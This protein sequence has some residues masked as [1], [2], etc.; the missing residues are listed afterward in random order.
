MFE[1]VVRGSEQS[2]RQAF[3]SLIDIDV[4]LVFGIAL[5]LAYGVSR[6]VVAELL[7]FLKWLTTYGERIDDSEQVLRIRRIETYFS[8][9]LALVRAFIFV[10]AIFAAWQYTHPEGAPLALIGASTIFVVVAGATVVPLLRDFTAGSTMIAEQWYNV[11]DFVSLEPFAKV[12]GIVERI[13]LRSTRIR[14]LNGEIIWVHNQTIQGVHVAPKGVR[15]LAMDL[16]VK[17]LDKGKDL[18]NHISKT[19]PVGPAMLVQPLAIMHT[20]KLGPKLWHITATCQTTPGREWLIEEFAVKAMQEEDEDNKVQVI[21]HGPL[22]R[23]A[24]VDAERRFGRAIRIK[25]DT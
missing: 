10:I 3:A 18:V 4:V 7:Y 20:Q 14:S 23:N 8:V 11:G 6:L 19:L 5:L 16:F 24:D 13:T 25:K 22:V 17:D 1:E 15:T 21:A 12:S 9:A 2:V